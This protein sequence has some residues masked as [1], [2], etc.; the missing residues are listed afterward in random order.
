MNI[1]LIVELFPLTTIFSPR[2][3]TSQSRPSASQRHDFNFW[4]SQHL[5]SESL[6]GQQLLSF[7]PPAATLSGERSGLRKC[8]SLK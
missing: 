7:L 1:L 6:K 8:S 5:A 2:A 4:H 3:L